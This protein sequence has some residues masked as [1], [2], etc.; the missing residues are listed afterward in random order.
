MTGVSIAIASF[1]R[2]AQEE[3]RYL[4]ANRDRTCGECG[5]WNRCPGYC[6]VWG[7]CRHVDAGGDGEGYMHR[8]TLAVRNNE[9]MNFTERNGNEQQHRIHQ[10]QAEALGRR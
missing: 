7:W 8:D 3:E 4:K 10:C 6:C 2:E 1:E 5:E 9:C